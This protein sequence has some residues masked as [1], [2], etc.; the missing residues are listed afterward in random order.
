MK[1]KII[2]SSSVLVVLCC[3]YFE[4]LVSAAEAEAGNSELT[5]TVPTTTVE[6]KVEES[7]LAPFNSLKLTTRRTE[8]K[9]N[10][11]RAEI[12][13]CKAGTRLFF[14]EGSFV[15]SS[16]KPVVGKVR[17]VVE[18]CFDLDEMLAAKLSTTSGNRRLETA[19]MIKV[20]AFA[21]RTEVSLKED[22]RYNIYFPI[23][24]D[25]KDDFELFY[26]Q[27]DKNGMIDWRLEKSAE[28]I[29]ETGRVSQAIVNDCF[30][31]ISASQYRCGTRIQEMDYFN[32][33]LI[34]GQ[35]LNQWF[36]SNFN[37]DPQM[38]DDF[39]ENRM[40]SQITF[41]VNRDGSFRDY[42]I[43]HSSKAEYD[44]L[45]ADA[46][47]AMPSL[48][49]EKFMPV[50]SEDHACILSFG[51]QQ[52]RSA[53]QFVDRFEKRHDST[54]PEEKM[55]DVS[56]ADLNYYVFSSTELG[57]INCDR[58]LQND[59]P[60]VDVSVQAPM[61]ENAQVSMVF[62][63]DKCILSAVKQ[64]DRYVFSGVPANTNVRLITLHN[65]DGTPQMEVSQINTS[66]RS[67]SVRKVEP[68]TLA[69]LDRALC[70]N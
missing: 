11:D 31:Q 61:C 28:P 4:R 19:G 70:W 62:D 9:I 21:G 54:D 24:G 57:W 5:Q 50:Y 3:V 64:G 25:R 37:P 68:I 43:S 51:R 40:Y 23:K 53:K 8:T 60:L 47:S 59:A 1:N 52:E 41:H 34:N 48:D 49:M 30:V 2:F 44:R 36:V 18:E 10:N 20:R 35:N 67:Y 45:L 29:D 6:T 66:C 26:G 7:Q 16:G 65:P 14:P 58:F 38:L 27:Q 13:E 69:D 55:S 12:V 33:P 39:C 32:W 22:G 46:L 56:T 15:Y 63:R 17:L 42:Y